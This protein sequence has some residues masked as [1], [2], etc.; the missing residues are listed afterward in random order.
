MD[1]RTKIGKRVRT[2]RKSLG[3]TQTELGQKAGLG[4]ETVSRI[5]RGVQ[6]VTFDNIDAIGAAVGIPLSE[7]CKKEEAPA[8]PLKGLAQSREI[9]ELL[10]QASPYQVELVYKM[11]QMILD[12][13]KE[14]LID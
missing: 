11:V 5:E 8:Q 12:Y 14:E 3:W 4:T 6:G 10:E 7:F 13:S 9:V 2:V 1:I